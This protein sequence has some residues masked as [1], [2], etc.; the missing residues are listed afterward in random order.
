M[1]IRKSGPV[2]TAR[3]ARTN[4]DVA[5]R[6]FRIIFL[7]YRLP[8]KVLAIKKAARPAAYF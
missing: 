6:Y 3:P 1:Q 4:V 8:L 2:H 5:A 7:R